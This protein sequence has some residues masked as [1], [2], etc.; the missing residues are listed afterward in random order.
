MHFDAHLAIC[1][2]YCYPKTSR[3]NFDASD[4]GHPA[5]FYHD[6]LRRYVPKATVDVLFP[7]D[8]WVEL[9]TGANLSSYDAYIWTG[10]DLT[11]Y[12]HDD[13]R[14]TRQI[15][16]ARAIYEAGVPCYGSCWGVQM[17]AVAAGGEV[18][19][20]PKGREWFLARDIQLT[21][22]GRQS[23]LYVG[24]PRC[25]DGFIMHLDEVTRLPP[26]ATLLAT[27]EHTHVQ[28]LEVK[29][30][31]GTFWATQYHPEY[32]L[33]EMARLIKARAKPLIKEGFFQETAEVHAL[34]DKTIDLHRHP[35]SQPLREELNVGDDILTAEIKE[36][37]LRNWIDHLVLPSLR[38]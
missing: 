32:N 5:D 37:E 7:A 10:S 14:V 28:A 23:P 3:D 36:V 13:P 6:F 12:H 27:N 35:D 29:H 22:E 19:K 16:L 17:A 4:V 9:P 31:K 8:P 20:N 2:L 21:A 26:G 33:Y 15:D 25:F 1:I 18:K 34:A 24:K 30:G 11:I 38:R